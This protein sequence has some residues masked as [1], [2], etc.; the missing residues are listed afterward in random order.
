[1]RQSVESEVWCLEGI[2]AEVVRWRKR[3]RE[4]GDVGLILR[5]EMF[6]GRMI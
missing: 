1:L 5:V 4:S 6:E 3:R 2:G